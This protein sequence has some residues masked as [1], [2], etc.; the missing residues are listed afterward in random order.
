MKRIMEKVSILAL[1]FILT[2]SFS[3]SS[4]QSAMFAYY[5]GIPHSMIELLI[6]LPSAGIML[7]LIFNKWIGRLF[8][9]RQMIVIGLVAYALCGFIPLISPAYPVVFLSRVIFGMAVGLLNVSAIAIISERYKGKERVQTLGIR[10]SAEV[11]GTAVLTFG[12]SL[13][14][15]F[16]WQAAFL[17]YGISIPILLLYLLFVPYASKT[18]GVEEKHRND[19][20]TASQWRTALG[21][22]VVA[23]S[24][25][26]SNVMIT[27]RIPSVVEQVGH[28]TAQTAGLILAAMQFVGILAGL[29][30]SPLTQLFRDRL[31]LVSGVAY[32]LTQILIG[33][34]TN[35]WMLAIVT[36]LAGFAYS[37]ALTTVYNVLSDQMPSGVLS[38]ATSIAVLGCSAGSIA[39]T[40]VLSLLGTVSSAPVFIFG[41]SGILMILVSFFGLWIVRK[42]GKGSCA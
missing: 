22:A 37:V 30:F 14:I 38:Q 17:V 41:F 16:G 26:L 34:S 35:L 4:A 11:V 19:Q 12:V 5:K 36:V 8:S 33:L 18:I 25:V 23:A 1:S 39:T 3:I 31:L 28:G 32:G 6:P 20:M 24:I 15:R 27:V 13:L 21:L 2:T 42:S 40:F 9:E 7:L 29:A 10:G